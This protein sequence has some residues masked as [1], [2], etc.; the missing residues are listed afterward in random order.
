[1][2]IDLKTCLKSYSPDENYENLGK[3]FWYQ[4]KKDY[5]TFENDHG[6]KVVRL[7]I[8]T[9]FFR[10]L[11]GVFSSS[12]LSPVLHAIDKLD[13]DKLPPKFLEKMLLI[14]KQKY[15][16][17]EC[18]LRLPIIIAKIPALPTYS[19]KPVR[20]DAKAPK[21]TPVQSNQQGPAAN[22]N[23]FHTQ[24]SPPITNDHANKPQI[25]VPTPAKP[26]QA[27]ILPLT[28]A[29]VDRYTN[30]NPPSRQ[31]IPILLNPVPQINSLE[32]F[33][34]AV[35]NRSNCS[36]LWF[37]TLNGLGTYPKK[38]LVKIVEHAASLNWEDLT[39]KTTIELKDKTIE[40]SGFARLALSLE[41]S[42]LRGKF[43]D[44]LAVGK[45]VLNELNEEQWNK[46]IKLLFNEFHKNLLPE[47][48][49][50]LTLEE[51]TF[52]MEIGD[53]YRISHLINTCF[54][55]ISDRETTY[56]RTEIEWILKSRVFYQKCKGWAGFRGNNLAYNDLLISQYLKGLFKGSN[57]NENQK[58]KDL[59]RI[60][61]DEATIKFIC[62]SVAS[63]TILDAPFSRD[64]VDNLNEYISLVGKK[65][66]QIILEHILLKT[67]GLSDQ[68]FSL[69]S[70]EELKKLTYELL[71]ADNGYML[72]DKFLN[73]TYSVNLTTMKLFIPQWK[74]LIL[75]Q[76]SFEQSLKLVKISAKKQQLY[77]YYTWIEKYLGQGYTKDGFEK[78]HQLFNASEKAEDLLRVNAIWYTNNLGSEIKNILIAMAYCNNISQM[79]ADMVV[80]TLRF[81]GY[82]ELF[83]LVLA[84]QLSWSNVERCNELFSTYKLSEKKKEAFFIAIFK[85][86]ESD[87]KLVNI[88]YM[89]GYYSGLIPK[90]IPKILPFVN[91]EKLLK[92]VVASV[93]Q[94]LE[95]GDPL[96]FLRMHKNKIS[97]DPA[98]VDRILN[99]VVI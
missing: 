40:I 80:S 15:P 95:E 91:S 65:E 20:G 77:F 49:V 98:V 76:M 70:H 66:K 41:S 82:D 48:E 50:P 51:I 87:E 73:M 32:A 78:I 11:L 86:D 99:P 74:K 47:N 79:R 60:R 92:E 55:K 58:L 72:L 61:K 88:R 18:P 38:M 26:T 89:I 43:Q 63:K 12:H 83:Y 27:P 30:I 16:G 56:D 69:F 68:L 3:G 85:S 35:N 75:E 45:T 84:N 10:A 71:E 57:L 1:M 36:R 46:L 37:V 25:D 19:Q 64:Q 53:T 97:L 13:K 44:G 23:N 67:D 94:N 17:Q 59:S 90:L 9:R 2:A 62:K 31:P 14:W 34:A 6:W 54:G 4:W 24:V 81:E 22:Q 5:L 42:V 96:A 52:F 93:K 21:P 28:Q 8:F 7:T 33:K 39:K 29:S